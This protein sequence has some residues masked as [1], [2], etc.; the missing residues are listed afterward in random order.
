MLT[1]AEEI[2]FV[3]AI[4]ACRHETIHAGARVCVLEASRAFSES[5][6][7]GGPIVRVGDRISV[8]SPS[9]TGAI[10]HVGQEL[11]KNEHAG[12]DL[13]GAE[14]QAKFKWQRKLMAGGMCEASCFT[15][16]G[17]E[18]SCVCLPLG[19]YHNMAEL[20]R[21]A[22]PDAEPD[23]DKFAQVGREHIALNDFHNLIT[24]LRGCALG[25]GD[26]PSSREK[27]ETLYDKR[28]WVI[29]QGD[30]PEVF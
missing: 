25:L 4:G 11:E 16:W 10:S 20:D 27:L 29:G 19:N 30:R 26:A 14:R 22:G 1:R 24:L 5:P 12:G 13:D 6:I 18:S 28:S 3:G 8:F 2:G 23:A 15:L 7:G 21:V 9:L 17:Y